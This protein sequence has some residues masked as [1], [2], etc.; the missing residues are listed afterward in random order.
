[1]KHTTADHNDGDL[2]IP[3]QQEVLKQFVMTQVLF[4]LLC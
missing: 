1:M 2:F 4:N 3:S